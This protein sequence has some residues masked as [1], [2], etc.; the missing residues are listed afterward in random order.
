MV[1]VLYTALTLSHEIVRLEE[2]L[3]RHVPFVS[4]IVDVVSHAGGL[5]LNLKYQI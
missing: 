3:G 4:S 1:Q 5:N 2:Q